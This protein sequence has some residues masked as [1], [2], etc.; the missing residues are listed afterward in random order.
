MEKVRQVIRSNDDFFCHWYCHTT[1]TKKAKSFKKK[2]V[3]TKMKW[4][5]AD[6]FIIVFLIYNSFIH[7]FSNKYGQQDDDD[8]P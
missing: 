5:G 3:I 2:K 1:K 8:D 7:S 4:N 6:E